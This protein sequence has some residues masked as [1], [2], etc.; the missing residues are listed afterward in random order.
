MNRIEF[1]G[2]TKRYYIL[3]NKFFI[4]TLKL[5]MQKI[6]VFILHEFHLKDN[7]KIYDYRIAK[8]II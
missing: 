1:G 6:I 4:Q 7:Q 5:F 8:V 2:E 3:Y